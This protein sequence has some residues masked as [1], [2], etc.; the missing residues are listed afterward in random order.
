MFYNFFKGSRAHK[1]F[2]EVV[3]NQ[4]LMKDISKLSLVHQTYGFEVFHSV[5]NIFAPKNNHF[6]YPA[7]MARYL[8]NA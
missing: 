1:L 7:M 8:L 5:I 2:W 3:E 6:F 4:F